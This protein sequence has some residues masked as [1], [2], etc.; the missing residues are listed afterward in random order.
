M[1]SISVLISGGGS[2]LQSLIDACS[3]GRLNGKINM[4]ISDREAFGLE[5]AEKAGIPAVLVDRKEHKSELSGEIL[6]RI[7]KDS[8]LIVLAGYLSI[9][10]HKF[11]E[12]WGGKIINIHPALLPE[13]GGKG[14]YGMNVHRAVIEAGKKVSGCTVHYV[15]TGVDTGEIILRKEVVVLPED[16]PEDLQKRIIVEEHKALVEAVALIIDKKH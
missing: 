4:V 2:N 9:L 3:D 13:F 12:A 10:S 1:F 16:S 6:K 14:M 8:D 5:R 15:D 11:I 7:P